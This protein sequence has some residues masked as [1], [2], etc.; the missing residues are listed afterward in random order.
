[1]TASAAPTPSADS[2]LIRCD[3]AI[4]SILCV[5]V[6]VLLIIALRTQWHQREKELVDQEKVRLTELARGERP[7]DHN[8][9][10]ETSGCWKTTGRQAERTRSHLTAGTEQDMKEGRSG[11]G[12]NRTEAVTCKWGTD[13][14]EKGTHQTRSWSSDQSFMR[15]ESL[16]WP[17]RAWVHRTVLT[18]W[19]VKQ[20]NLV[21]DGMIT[22][23]WHV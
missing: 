10:L 1:V 20:W 23:S 19:R 12:E 9:Y 15:A 22:C 11:Q 6:V 3:V 5:I 16:C 8:E 13:R 14:D 17:K 2:V 18:S 7:C 21:I 4:I